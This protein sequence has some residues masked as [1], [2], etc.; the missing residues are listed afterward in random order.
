MPAYKELYRLGSRVRVK[1]RE[2]LLEFQL[3]WKHHHPLSD[4][5]L[6]FAGCSTTVVDVG[7]YHG[8]DVLYRLQDVTGTWHEA[9]LESES[10]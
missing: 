4:D 2:A 6:E 1:P 3:N 8:G 7:F 5:M 10:G 9:C